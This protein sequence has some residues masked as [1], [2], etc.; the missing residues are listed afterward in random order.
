MSAKTLSG[1]TLGANIELALLEPQLPPPC[2]NDESD[3]IIAKALE[4]ASRGHRTMAVHPFHVAFALLYRAEDING[5]ISDIPPRPILEIPLFWVIL[6]KMLRDPNDVGQALRGEIINLPD[7]QP[8]S[9]EILGIGYT[10]GM[11]A[12]FRK[13]QLYQRS[14]GDKFIAPH[15]ILRGLFDDAIIEEILGKLFLPKAKLIKI[16]EEFRP[17]K[18]KVLT[19]QS[20]PK[21]EIL[22]MF[23]DDLTEL[24]LEG[25][26]DPVL[27]RD[28]EIYRLTCVLS[29]RV[30]NNAV[31]IGEPG[32][33]K[34]AVIEGLALRIVDRENRDS[35]PRDLNGR[36]FRLDMGRLI[37]G[38][39]CH[40]VYEKRV[41]AI[42]A[43]I[44]RNEDNGDRIIL[45][46]DEF[47]L[48]ITGK[49][50]GG[51]GGIDAANL[52][53]PLLAR[54][55]LHCVGATTSSEYDNCILKDGSLERRFAKIA[56]E[57][58]TV[59]QA[60]TILRGVCDS[61]EQHHRVRIQDKALVAAAELAKRYLTTRRLP[62]SAIDLVDEA[63]AFS[64]VNRET[65][66]EDIDKLEWQKVKLN[67]DTHSLRREKDRDSRLRVM[68]A[69]KEL[70]D[71]DVQL[72]SLSIKYGER[73]AKY[74]KLLDSERRIQGLKKKRDMYTN[75]AQ[76][77][78][79]RALNHELEEEERKYETAQ[80]HLADC[81]RPED[82]ADVLSRWT[83][84]PITKK[85]ESRTMDIL[86]EKVVGQPEAV[87]AVRNAIQMSRMDLANPSRPMASLLFVGPSGCGKTHLAKM[88]AASVFKAPNCLIEIEG[89]DYC[90]ALTVPRLIGTP[91]TCTGFDQTGQLTEFVKRKPHCVVLVNEA[92]KMC[93]KIMSLF[94][95]ILDYGE[96]TDGNRRVIDFRNCFI[97]FT[98]SL[99]TDDM[100]EAID[101][102]GNL[103]EGIKRDFLIDTVFP[104]EF[105]NRLDD[106]IFFRDL[107][108]N[109]LKRIMHMRLREI[110]ERMKERNVE[111]FIND[112]AKQRLWRLVGKEE[113]YGARDLDR[114]LFKTLISPLSSALLHHDGEV[115]RMNVS[116]DDLG[117]H[118]NVVE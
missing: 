17:K 79:L 87:E 59:A 53:K 24:A 106:V 12:V 114:L 27:C 75:A 62:D 71:I 31:L 74:K 34:S 69:E 13:A 26:I 70:A 99:S 81:I 48:I 66:P 92:E 77:K 113:A 93:M 55:K 16:M 51:D 22:T 30:K 7:D 18:F 88:V 10:Q 116:V 8:E 46:I 61:Y 68:E 103:D 25:K 58:P 95:H 50:I 20:R 29:R 63:C 91:V 73:K 37:A 23:A 32:V 102:D 44:E 38:T 85:Y 60:K 14:R 109:D 94:Q 5:D 117:V 52:F 97:I 115:A 41:E 36:I 9:Q 111:L 11:V 45:F 108:P 15:H 98:S 80:T 89:S 84:I 82:I 78:N 110:T 3:V 101:A 76:I 1:T 112:D 49:G 96:I 39:A 47:H 67:M 107:G 19:H 72:A 83:S 4:I 2:F 6:S 86:E 43:E 33:G 104:L 90:D 64:K 40:G 54:G 56:I 21:Y 100:P 65:R 57:E 35:V 28:D 118:V 42:L 105:V